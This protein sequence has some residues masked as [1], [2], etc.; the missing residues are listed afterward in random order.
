[1]KQMKRLAALL[2]TCCIF[3][4][5]LPAVAET[6][7]KEGDA[8]AEI[9]AIKQRML[10][11]GYYNGN[12]SHNRFNDTMTERVKQLQKVNG[13]TQTGVID[14]ELYTLIFSDAVLMKNGK[15]AT[16]GTPAA[17]AEPENEQQPASEPAVTQAP[18]ND[19]GKVLY[20]EG[21]SGAEIMAIKQRMLELGYYSGSIANN[22]FN[23]TMAKYIKELQKKNGL[24]E[25]GVINEALYALIFSPNVNT[26][27]GYPLGTLAKGDSGAKVRQLRVRM[28]EL[29]YFDSTNQSSDFDDLLVGRVKLLQRMNGFEQTGVVSS[30]LYDY[31]MSGA[32][33]VCGEHVNPAYNAS[34]RFNYVLDGSKLYNVSASGNV[35]IFIIDYFANN[36]LASVLRA[37]PHMLDPFHDFTYY[38]NC[39]PRYI[40][41]YPSVTHMLTGNDFDPSLLVGEFFEQSW[42]SESAN[43]IYNTIHSLGY[44]FRYYYYTSIS[45]GATAWAV[46]KVDNLVDLTASPGAT[47]E[48][49]YSYTNFFDNLKARGLT[50][51]QTEKKYIQ[52]IHLRGAHGPYSAA[53]DGTYKADASREENIAGYMAMVADYMQRMKDAGLYDD[54]TIIITADH[55][56]KGENMQVVYWIKQA[57]EQH[58][59]IVTNSAPISHDDFPGTI[60]SVIGGDYGAY[61]TS[62][63]DWKPDDQRQ[64]TCSVVGRDINTYPQ[65][66]CY[67]DL[68]LGSHN[69]WKTYTY[70]GTGTTLVQTIKR[71]KY[72]HVPLAQSFN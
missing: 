2:L 30:E 69:F 46:G 19:G 37:Y 27:S 54:A 1:M 60:L 67:S 7:Y 45:D 8:G 21:M 59:S 6:L 71:G 66:S 16:T 36:Y 48:P 51:D 40:G 52:M 47:V 44:E 15:K 57:G 33:T 32:C 29:Q 28:A 38:S 39:D 23:E 10:E 42:T 41:T 61:G 58:D 62:I 50:V 26:K 63:F 68:G 56:D 4:T 70:T 24:Q 25:T 18:Q 65:V 64:R 5:C 14:E 17:A 53:A 35:I 13:L 34:T 22:A 20:K 31:I 3:F 49:I 12:I 72:T 9:M 43:F 11:L 55:G